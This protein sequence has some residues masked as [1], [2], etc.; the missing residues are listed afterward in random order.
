MSDFT[1]TARKG[2]V[3]VAVPRPV[4]LPAAEALRFASALIRAANEADPP[5][6]VPAG[7][8]SPTRLRQGRR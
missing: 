7:Y 5:D 2:A 6:L 8:K 4:D 3:S 1:V